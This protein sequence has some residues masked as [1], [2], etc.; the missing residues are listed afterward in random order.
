MRKDT[1]KKWN[2]MTAIVLIMVWVL[3]IGSSVWLFIQSDFTIYM[4][5]IRIQ[6]EMEKESIE[7]GIYEKGTYPYL[8][9]DL[10]GEVVY[11]DDEFDY[12]P[13]DHVIAEE[14]LQN[15]KSFA[16]KYNGK[17]KCPLLLNDKNGVCKG[18]VVYLVS[19]EQLKNATYKKNSEKCF[20][21]LVLGSLVSLFLILFR[22]RY[23]NKRILNPLQKISTSANAIIAGNYDVEVHRIY[24]SELQ[25][26]EIGDLTYSFELMRD[27]LKEKQ[28][29]EQALR[30]SQQELISCIS[31][32][33]RTPI[34]TIKAYGEGL[35]DGIAGSEEERKEFL[36]ILL[37]KT[38]LLEEMITELLEYS[39]TQLNQL[40]IVRKD[41]YFQTY[42]K[43]IARELRIYAEQQGFTFKQSIILEDFLINIDE[44]R[45]TEVL[46]NLIE[47]SMK[48]SD[49]T[50]GVI[51]FLV[52]R[53][54]KYVTFHVKDNGIGIGADDIPYVFDKFYRAEKSRSSNVPGS[55]LGLS[56]CKYI[57]NQ[58]NG[59]IYCRSRKSQGSEFW[60]TIGI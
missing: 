27:E 58:H 53:E 14:M 46:Y 18:F 25:S 9:F 52:T 11:A 35:R 38:N 48:Y 22:T 4:N 2:T 51:E 32:D 21:P 30:K 50:N 42:I 6:L 29:S 47:N 33:L 40:N 41:I 10:A 37:N 59:D 13:G 55:G 16:K 34:S 7:E 1:I 43:E 56:I 5:D 12:L 20:F 23:C 28:M 44:K 19:K 60:F 15:D 26:N 39:N 8:V 3:S 54:E 17:E 45:I 36:T 57:V 24:E 49:K 31:H